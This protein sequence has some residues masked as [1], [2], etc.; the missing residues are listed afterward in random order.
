[1]IQ[2]IKNSGP[3]QPLTAIIQIVDMASRF[4]PPANREVRR[5][6]STDD[7]LKVDPLFSC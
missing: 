5:E 6:V 3:H 4:R 2:N 1:M 7:P